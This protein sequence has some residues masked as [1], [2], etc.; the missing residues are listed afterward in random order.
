MTEKEWKTLMKL[1]RKAVKEVYPPNELQECDPG[2]YHK[3]LLELSLFYAYYKR[4]FTEQPTNSVMYSAYL[5][6]CIDCEYEPLNQIH[7]SRSLVKYFGLR[8]VDRK[9]RG[10]KHRIFVTQ[11]QT[12]E[13][14][15]SF[16][17]TTD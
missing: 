11:P 10:V 17:K 7:F 8:V 15:S 16:S 6:Y 2:S 9:V 12:T 14:N 5:Q 3:Q 13:Q 1:L 4:E